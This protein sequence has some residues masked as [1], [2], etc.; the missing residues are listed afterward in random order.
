MAIELATVLAAR[1]RGWTTHMIANASGV[2]HQAVSLRLMVYDDPELR[3]KK[4]RSNTRGNGKTALTCAACGKTV[5]A[6][7]HRNEKYCSWECSAANQREIFDEQVLKAIDL[8]RNANSW[9][10]VSKVMGYSAQGI[11]RRIWYY[12]HENGLLTYTVVWGIWTTPG[13]RWRKRTPSWKWLERKTG[14]R[15]R[16]CEQETRGDGD[17]KC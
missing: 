9:T 13:A 14:L 1:R 17:A 2:T 15:P 11:Q 12:L 16:V 5:W 7:Y 8:R 6:G 4:F 3:S 10:Y